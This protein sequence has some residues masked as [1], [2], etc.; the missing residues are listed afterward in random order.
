MRA[1]GKRQG[2]QDPQLAAGQVA[3]RR[4]AGE[5]EDEVLAALWSSAEPMTA[6]QAREALDGEL[7]YTTVLTI[8]ARLSA[9]G[10][11]DRNKNGR[12]YVYRPRVDPDV[13]TAEQMRRLLERRGDRPAVLA[14]F[15]DGLTIADERALRKLMRKG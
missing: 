4:A 2:I 3:G 11:V 6:A 10:L 15:V 14:H 1:K 13:R 12:A 9:K 8:L 5:L 7:A